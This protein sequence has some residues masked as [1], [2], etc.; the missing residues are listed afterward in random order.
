MTDVREFQHIE[1][2]KKKFFKWLAWEILFLLSAWLVIY[3][4]ATYIVAWFIL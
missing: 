3:L 1:R 2:M 4:I